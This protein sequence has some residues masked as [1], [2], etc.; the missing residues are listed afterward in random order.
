MMQ[1]GWRKIRKEPR[2]MLERERERERERIYYSHL[3]IV[4]SKVCRIRGKFKL[5][6]N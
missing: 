4:D 5:Q 1:K 6:N 2:F 3:L